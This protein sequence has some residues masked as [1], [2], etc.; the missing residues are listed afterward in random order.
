MGTRRKTFELCRLSENLQVISSAIEHKQDGSMGYLTFFREE[1]HYFRKQLTDPKTK[2]SVGTSLEVGPVWLLFMS[3]ECEA[4]GVKLLELAHWTPSSASKS[5]VS[6]F[7]ADKQDYPFVGLYATEINGTKHR[8][9]VTTKAGFVEQNDRSFRHLFSITKISPISKTTMFTN[10]VLGY[11][12][13]VRAPNGVTGELELGIQNLCFEYNEIMFKKEAYGEDKEAFLRLLMKEL[14]EETRSVNRRKKEKL[15]KTI[16]AAMKNSSTYCPPLLT[17][18]GDAMGE[19]LDVYGL[20]FSERITQAAR[21]CLMQ[22][23]ANWK[24]Q[25]DSILEQNMTVFGHGLNYAFTQAIHARLCSLEVAFKTEIENRQKEKTDPSRTVSY[26]KTQSR[27]RSPKRELMIVEEIDYTQDAV[28][29]V[30]LF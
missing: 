7:I 8:I 12:L 25:Y 5:V 4:A 10:E 18:P 20:S 15:V 13:S 3:Q 16:L 26:N 28:R 14:R 9:A 30:G 24:R 6:R 11:R 27:S 21:V 1:T 22:K 2:I 23:D 29:D 19:A 17:L